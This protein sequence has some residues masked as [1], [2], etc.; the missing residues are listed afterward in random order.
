M[1]RSK[2]RARRLITVSGNAAVRVVPDQV[3]LTLGVETWNKDLVAAKTENELRIKT[4]ITAVGAHGV[5]SKDV[6]TDYVS[7]ELELKDEH[8]ERGY[9]I[10]RTV[11]GYWVRRSA[12]VTLRD[13][14]KFEPLLTSVVEAGANHVH[15]I[16]FETTELRKF[17]DQARALAIQAAREKAI[18]LAAELGQKIG[19][20]E[21]ISEGHSGWGASYG[22]YWG[23]HRGGGM[24]QNIMQMQALAGG[25]APDGA[26]EPGRISVTADVS[27][28]FRLAT[29]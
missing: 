29:R 7:I 26:L 16:A 15:G 13:V 3:T 17:R 19:R 14:S 22:S 12:I 2:A 11:K 6:Q 21:S 25:A 24:S 27:V 10:G 8:D 20:P 4:M 23:G 9:A 28:T 5:G 1:A 18:A